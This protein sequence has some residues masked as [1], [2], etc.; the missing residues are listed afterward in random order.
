[1]ATTLTT[2]KVSCLRRAS[3]KR[4]SGNR[5]RA[6]SGRARSGAGISAAAPKSVEKGALVAEEIGGGPKLGG[7]AGVH[8]EHGVTAQDRLQPVRH[9]QRRRARRNST[10]QGPLDQ[11]VL[12]RL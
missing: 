8:H 4:V 10:R 1:M 5:R 12:R 2:P 7:S 9:R 6:H 11:L 3:S